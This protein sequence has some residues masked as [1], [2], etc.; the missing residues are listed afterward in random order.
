MPMEILHT[1]AVFGIAVM[2][3]MGIGSAGLMVLW[4]TAVL[5]IPQLEAQGINLIFFLISA[6]A[7]MLIHAGK[8]HIPLF[9]VLLLS[10]TGIAAAYFGSRTAM[11]LPEEWVRRLFGGML[12]VSGAVSLLRDSRKS[13]KK[14][15]KSL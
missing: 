6:C 1:A 5:G 8:R 4:L 11:L 3:G 14:R 15:R 9:P 12:A 7:S 2:S 10:C 13:R